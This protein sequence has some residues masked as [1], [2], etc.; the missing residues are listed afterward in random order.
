[1]EASRE[2]NSKR[3]QWIKDL[4]QER[5]DVELRLENVV[6]QVTD[7]QQQNAQLRHNNES[8][9]EVWKRTEEKLL[10]DSKD[11]EVQVQ[12]KILG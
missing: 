10:Q 2:E 5:K 11:L 8:K 3:D 9:T 4:E 7:L 6:L 1:M 12:N